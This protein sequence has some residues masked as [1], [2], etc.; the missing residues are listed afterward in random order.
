MMNPRLFE[1][2]K[3]VYDRRDSLG[4]A[5]DQMKDVVDTY[6]NFVRN[7][8]LLSDADKK[9]LMDVN[10]TLADLYMQFN[11]NLLSATNDFRIV[12]DDESRLAGLP[13]SSVAQAAE[14]AKAAGMEGKWLFTLQAP[15]RLPLLQYA[16]D[17]DLRREMYEGYV[18]LAS[19]V[20]R[21]EEHTSE[22]QSRI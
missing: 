17:R 8:A 18:N 13:A 22:L 2:V 9:K 14:A 10:A 21:S 6:N 1:R 15:S 5:P 7:G 11:R 4:L 16:D 12:V 3:S 19:S 20:Q